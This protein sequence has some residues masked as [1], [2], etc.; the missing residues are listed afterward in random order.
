MRVLIAF[1]AVFEMPVLAFF[2]AKL[3]LV[4]AEQLKSGFRYAILVFFVLSA[5]LTPPDVITQILMVGPLT[6]LYGISILV[7]GMAAR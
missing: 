1:G 2:F 4:N 3:G 6:I 5:V 7:A